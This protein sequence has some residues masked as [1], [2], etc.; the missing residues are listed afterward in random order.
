MVGL[1]REKSLFYFSVVRCTSLSET[2]EMAEKIR[3]NIF[4]DM[5]A[6]LKDAAAYERGEHVNLRVTRI[7]SPGGSQVGARIERGCRSLRILT[8]SYLNSVGIFRAP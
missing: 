8:F 3:V 6:A 1:R 5:K 7:P 4:D 2:L